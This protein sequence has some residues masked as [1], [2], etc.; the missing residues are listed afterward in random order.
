MLSGK[1]QLLY[2]Y[3]PSYLFLVNIE[4]GLCS[5]KYFETSDNVEWYS[6]NSKK[7]GILMVKHL[8]TVTSTILENNLM[9]RCIVIPFHECHFAVPLCSN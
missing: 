4:D 6:V 1:G 9:K 7:L 3:R 2:Y 5:V 8:S